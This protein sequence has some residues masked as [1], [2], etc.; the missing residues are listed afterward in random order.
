MTNKKQKKQIALFRVQATDL[1]PIEGNQL[2]RTG[3][4]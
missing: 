1:S 2:E 3:V 4:A